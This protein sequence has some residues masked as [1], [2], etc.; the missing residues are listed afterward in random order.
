MRLSLSLGAANCAGQDQN[1][2][3]A[4]ARQS[5]EGLEDSRSPGR[6][7][8]SERIASVFGWHPGLQG[9]RAEWWDRGGLQCQLTA[10]S[11]PAGDWGNAFWDCAIV[12]PGGGDGG[13]PA[14]GFVRAGLRD[15]GQEA[16]QQHPTTHHAIVG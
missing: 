1:S 3:W 9:T 15:G 6:A 4:V 12:A 2:R 7:A 5:C 14:R 10:L 13:A 8:A 11:K 16:G